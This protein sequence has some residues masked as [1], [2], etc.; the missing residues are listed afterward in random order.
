ML[1]VGKTDVFE[2]QYMEKFRMFASQFGE[3]VQYERDRGARDIGLHLSHKLKSGQERMS[4]ALCWFQMKGYMANTLTAKDFENQDTIGISLEVKH[5]QFWYL[6]PMPTYLV[7]YIESVN[8]FLILNIQ[9][10]VEKKWDRN[11]LTLNQKTATIHIP[12]D[13]I[14]DSQAFY[15]I[16]T[17]SDLEV[18]N[19]VL[20]SDSKNI[21]ICQ[22][23]YNLI[24]RLGKSDKRR[25]NHKVLFRE[26]LTKCRGELYILE[27]F[28]TDQI[29]QKILRE[30]WEYLMNWDDLKMKYPYLEFYAFNWFRVFIWLTCNIGH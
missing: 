13:S 14:L 23:D 26:W 8:I 25:V 19:K 1:P 7:L 16:L 20:V 18:W 29:D 10:Y 22:R 5:L 11:I 27:N 6:Q 30:H 2:R 9:K 12:S 28:L 24:W 15:L 4:Y 3:F 17:E 21:R